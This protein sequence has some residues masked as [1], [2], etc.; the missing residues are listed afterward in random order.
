MNGYTNHSFLIQLTLT[1][2][3]SFLVPLQL[4]HAVIRFHSSSVPPLLLGWT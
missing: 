3:L 2:T 4:R 1:I